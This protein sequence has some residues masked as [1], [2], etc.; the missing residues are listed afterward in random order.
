M[1]NILLILTGVFLMLSGCCANKV[2]YYKGSKP[3][4][5][6][7]EYFNGN[8]KA[9]GVVQDWRGRVVNRFDIDML[10]AWN[11]ANGTLDEDFT[12]IF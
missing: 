6:I 1:K 9:W 12:F 5:D 3:E 8:I 4:V 10:G 11:G 2:E 7:K